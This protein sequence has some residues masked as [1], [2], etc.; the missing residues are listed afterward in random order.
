MKKDF[1]KKEQN[2]GLFERMNIRYIYG[3][4]TKVYGDTL[5]Q[6]LN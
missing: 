6:T 5:G 3:S 2:Y 1:Y 4:L